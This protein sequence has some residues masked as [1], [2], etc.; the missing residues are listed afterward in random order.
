MSAGFQGRAKVFT[1][2]GVKNGL[3]GWVIAEVIA[4]MV[5]VKLVGFSGAILLSLASSLIGLVI[6]RRLGMEAARH[7]R[8][9]LTGRASTEGRILDGSLAVFGAFL[10]IVPGFVSDVVGLVLAAPSGREYVTRRLGL[11]VRREGARV[12]D[13]RPGVIDLSP[14]DWTVVEPPRPR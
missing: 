7:L 14:S 4:L 11:G 2:F 5:V 9:A 3:I 12:P 10:L 1:R 13:S 8:T 6:L